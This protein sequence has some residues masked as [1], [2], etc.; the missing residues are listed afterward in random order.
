MITNWLIEF[1]QKDRKRIGRVLNQ[2][3]IMHPSQNNIVI[4]G[5]LVEDVED[6]SIYHIPYY[7]L[8]KVFEPEEKEIQQEEDFSSSFLKTKKKKKNNIK[9]D[10]KCPDTVDDLPF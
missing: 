9:E 6:R 3:N 2:E 5:Y 1:F 8:K 10:W 7:D 4:T